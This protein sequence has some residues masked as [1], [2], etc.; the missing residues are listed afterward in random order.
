VKYITN[1]GL[2]N[3]EKKYVTDNLKTIFNYS[4]P[5]NPLLR[6][7]AAIFMLDPKPASVRGIIKFFQ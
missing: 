4:N 6:I 7:K 5:N 2:T 1:N 3:V